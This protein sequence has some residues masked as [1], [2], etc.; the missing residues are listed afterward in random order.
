MERSNVPFGPGLRPEAQ[1]LDELLLA[2]PEQ[3]KRLVA[4]GLPV[5]PFRHVARDVMRG[6]KAAIGE[7]RDAR[8]VVRLTEACEPLGRG[9]DVGLSEN[10][11]ELTLRLLHWELDRLRLWIG[12]EEVDGAVVGDRDDK[13]DL[14]LA[15]AR[16]EEV[17][18]RLAGMGQS[19]P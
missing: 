17:A 4:E 12:A 15:L 18:Q 9:Q 10:G 13:L 6:E 8:G 16:G 2:Q 3:R 5:G 19:P 1:R 11:L 14:R 7:A